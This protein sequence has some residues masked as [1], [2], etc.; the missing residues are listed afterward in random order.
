M[1]RLPKISIVTP[2]RN[3]VT[4]IEDCI[5][6]VLDQDYPNFE[7]IVVD[8]DSTDGTVALF[9]KY[10]H[11][12]WISEPDEGQSDAL[13]KGFRIA[14]GDYVGWLNADEYYLPGA[15]QALKQH[16]HRHSAD[17]I[18]GDCVFVG[19]DGKL[20]RL[21]PEPSL[22]KN[23]FLFYGCYVPT[24]ALFINKRVIKEG[25]L[26]DV[27]YNYVMDFE[28]L[29]RLVITGKTFSRLDRVLGAF[30]WHQ[31][32]KS[33]DSDQ[34]RKERLRVQKRFTPIQSD[35]ALDLFARLYQAKHVVKKLLLG[36]YYKQLRTRSYRGMETRWFHGPKDASLS[37]DEYLRKVGYSN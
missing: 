21:K 29:A 27:G 9:A 26:L 6:S 36:H 32:N 30:R 28:Y 5:R 18:F 7:H 3:S 19:A 12:R 31:D 10:P 15:F 2:S 4:F 25:L 20:L 37:F 22:D 16:A 23:M 34:R 13:N 14:T 35:H 33:H 17:V 11:L 8:G 1:K 24:V